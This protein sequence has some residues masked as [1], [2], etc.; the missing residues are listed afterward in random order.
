M[1]VQLQRRLFSVAEYHRMLEA[2]IFAEDDRVE[3]IA[4]ESAVDAILG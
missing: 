1:A 2:G 3:H 4:L